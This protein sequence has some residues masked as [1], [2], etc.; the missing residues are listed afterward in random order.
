MFSFADP[1]KL[2]DLYKKAGFADIDVLLADIEWTWP[3]TPED[4]WDY[5]QDVTVPFKPLFDS[6]PP[7]RRAEIDEAVLRE[8]SKFSDG[9]KVAFG[10]KFVL[11][12]A[13]R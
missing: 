2:R 6:V 13:I 11:A 10:A 3:G 5:F 9:N 7:E 4:V 12:S 8:I 1:E